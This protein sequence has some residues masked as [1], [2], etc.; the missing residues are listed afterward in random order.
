MRFDV[1][2][3]DWDLE[4]LEPQARA[5]LIPRMRQA[6]LDASVII[7]RHLKILLKQP[8]SGR[9]Y[10]SRRTRK[11]MHRA[12]APGE[13]PASDL[14]QY[15][16][17][18]DIGM[19]ADGI[20]I[21]AGIWSELWTRRGRRLEY[22]GYSRPSGG[23]QGRDSTGRFTK[24]RGKGGGGYIAPRPHVRRAIEETREA[25]EARLRQL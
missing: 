7:V 14:G 6:V 20:N 9:F 8:G 4:G 19:I 1:L 22:G 3:D 5:I 23:D 11:A 25:V 24:K 12:S 10:K 13:P 15:V 16:N 17:S 21:T 18:W 2:V